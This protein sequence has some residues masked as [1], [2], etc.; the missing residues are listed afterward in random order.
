VLVALLTVTGRAGAQPSEADVFVAEGILALEDKKYD[1][2]LAG[3]RQALQREPDHVEALYYAGV[4]LMAQNQA[5]EAVPFLERARKI[6]PSE[7]SVGFQLGL[8]YVG[9]NLFDEAS[10]LLEDVFRRD[11]GLD[12][13]GYYVGYLRYRK[14]NYQSA[15]QAFR[16]GRTTDPNI[17]QLT[18][19]YAGLALGKLG[20]P[21]QAAAEVEQALRLQP[22]SPLT[23]PAE[24]LRQSFSESRTQNE[25]KFRAY[26]RLGGFFDDNVTVR[27]DPHNS[28]DTVNALRPPAH[29]SFGELATL[30]LEYDWLKRG[31]WTSTVGYTFFTTYDDRLPSYNI[32]DHLATLN[33]NRTDV[34]ASM[35]LISGFQYAYEYLMLG[36]TE[37]LQRH[38]A[39]V[40][41]TLVEGP[42]N[43][44]NV[45]LKAEIKEF[46]EKLPISRDEF[47]DGSN[48]MIGF[49]HLFRFAEDRHFIKLGYQ[50]DFEDSEGR[51][52]VYLG[53][54]VLA[55]VQYTLP[56]NRVRLSYDFAF[57][58]RYY[59]NK[60]SLYPEDDPG[61]RRRKDDEY[62]HLIRVEVPLGAGFTAGIDYQGTIQRSNLAPYTYERN[63]YTV[64]VSWTY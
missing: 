43:L 53:H 42:H 49:V 23:A 11:P 54:R 13:L 10:P 39:S 7:I 26:L 29:E 46:V 45:T 60:N 50:C 2:A 25:R 52:Y 55:G 19:L 5:A 59:E 57:H 63:I 27:P 41:S 35:P 51:N 28:S 33:V 8:A 36:Q 47:Q 38:V 24:R 1:E 40:Y 31:P 22:V 20:L 48:Y 62:S 58:H 9:A 34:V 15:L 14:E 56:W 17:A 12:S 3:F 64:S 30:H 16:A 37:L 32:I 44:T 6:S 18:R 21:A 4:T 61:T